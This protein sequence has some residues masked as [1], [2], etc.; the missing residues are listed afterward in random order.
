MSLEQDRLSA[1]PHP[2]IRPI[3]AVL[4]SITEPLFQQTLVSVRAALLH[5]TVRRL[6]TALLIRVIATVSEPVT[7]EGQSHTLTVTALETVT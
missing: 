4:V 6:S 7:A 1:A 5:R 3:T 2:L